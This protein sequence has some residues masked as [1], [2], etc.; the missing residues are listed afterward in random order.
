V[1]RRQIAHGA[2]DE[3]RAVIDGHKHGDAPVDRGDEN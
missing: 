3:H 2:I 1:R